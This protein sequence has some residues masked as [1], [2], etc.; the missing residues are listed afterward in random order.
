MK[1]T[2]LPRSPKPL[3]AHGVTTIRVRTSGIANAICAA[4]IV[5][6]TRAWK[7]D[8]VHIWNCDRPTDPLLAML[9]TGRTPLVVSDFAS[10]SD[11]RIWPN[12]ARL[13]RRP[14]CRVVPPHAVPTRGF[15]V[16]DSTRAVPMSV[17]ATEPI[18][19]E[20]WE[21][22]RLTI[23][24]PSDAKIIGAIANETPREALKHL[25]WSTELISTV[26]ADAHFVLFR[27]RRSDRLER[28]RD[29]IEVSDRVHLVGMPADSASVLPRLDVFWSPGSEG[30]QASLLLEAVATGVPSLALDT[31]ETRALVGDHLRGRLF[32]RANAASVA[33]KTLTLLA[34]SDTLRATLRDSGRQALTQYRPHD[35]SNHYLRIYQEITQSR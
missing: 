12:A 27:R 31:A 22:F 9:G 13:L 14:F 30:G 20:D 3:G 11:P 35:A 6:A 32:G 23:Q 19:T 16:G 21:H 1:G 18:P 2:V 8:V 34:E 25:I 33:R 5:R 24:V 15:D 29:Q 17:V 7:P 10:R 28:F 26:R 4:R